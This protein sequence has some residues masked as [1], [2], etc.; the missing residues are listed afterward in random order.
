MGI[1]DM[2]ELGR[3][4]G[5]VS[6]LYGSKQGHARG[7]NNR[8]TQQ[9]GAVSKERETEILFQV[10]TFQVLTKVFDLKR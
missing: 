9:V 1:L 10:W 2:D 6:V 5:P 3:R 8:P 7:D 4:V